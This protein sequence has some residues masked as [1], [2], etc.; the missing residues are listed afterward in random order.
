MT[1]LMQAAIDLVVLSA[2]LSAYLAFTIFARKRS[3]FAVAMVLVMLLAL[4]LARSTSAS[5]GMIEHMPIIFSIFSIPLIFGGRGE[6]LAS[7]ILIG[8]FV[9]VAIQRLFIPV[10]LS[11]FDT[12]GALVDVLVL[13]LL[14]FGAQR[15]QSWTLMFCA[16][17]YLVQVVGH[18]LM[19]I[20]PNLPED[21]YFIFRT[22]AL[23]IIAFALPIF[24]LPNIL[25]IWQLRV[26]DAQALGLRMKKSRLRGRFIG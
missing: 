15:R 3:W 11:Q 4:F 23:P 9:V 24:C 12:S 13:S 18:V 16:A 19:L 17:L 1:I 25:R 21:V 26:L 10:V 6:I 2:C 8:E 5:L 22:A 14:T 20:G 7:A